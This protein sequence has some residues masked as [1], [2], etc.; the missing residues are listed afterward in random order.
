MAMAPPGDAT[1]IRYLL[2]QADPE[3]EEQFD[4]LSVTD[5]AFAERLRA[6]EHD[7][8]DAYVR[9]ELSPSDRERWKARYLPSAHG[10]DDLAVAQALAARGA[11]AG[12]GR[13]GA[14]IGAGRVLT[15]GAW[16]LLAAAAVLMLAIVGGYRLRHREQPPASVA[17]RTPQTSPPGPAPTP[18]L[19]AT[20]VIAMLLLPSV[21][22][23]HEPAT[24]TIPPGTTEVK[25]TLRLEPDEYRMY[26]IAARDL[27][28][29]RIVWNSN[30]VPAEGTGADRSLV[31]SIP[32]S[33]FQTRRYLI[34]V[35][36]GRAGAREV[37]AT[38]PLTVVLQ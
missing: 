31:V 25:L 9:G 37:V 18:A 14:G 19:P 17:E 27:T 7:L 16:W 32:A 6:I 22:S 5:P 13:S 29:N 33:A 4:E 21:R 35:S 23:V 34:N 20:H 28:S 3:N 24:L 30:E 15:R 11:V 36:A 38:Y 12:G 8:A 2:G 1:L 10:R 26:T